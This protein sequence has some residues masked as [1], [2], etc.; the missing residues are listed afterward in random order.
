MM[1]GYEELVKSVTE[2]ESTVPKPTV[3]YVKMDIGA[4]EALSPEP[5]RNFTQLVGELSAVESVQLP[6]RQQTPQPAAKPAKVMTPKQLEPMAPKA[7]AQKEATKQWSLKMPALHISIPGSGPKKQGEAIR[8]PAVIAAPEPTPKPLEVSAGE[9]LAKIVKESSVA[10]PPA[11]PVY[12]KSTRDLV[13]PKLSITDQVAELGKIVDNLREGRFESDQLAIVKEEIR[14]LAEELSSE[15]QTDPTGP[16]E[17]DLIN[18]RSER[19]T[20]ALELIKGY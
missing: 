7:K 16:F 1:K 20:K 10:P 18:L 3:N 9:E 17:Q 6:R 4:G 2:M 14:G 15:K 13:L 5:F 11:E 19:L 8:P 12:V